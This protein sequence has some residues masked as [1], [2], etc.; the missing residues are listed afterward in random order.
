MVCWYTLKTYSGCVCVSE[1]AVLYI[2]P[3]RHCAKC[4]WV[5]AK[6][7]V[8]TRD[9][10]NST[11]IDL[12]RC[13]V[14]GPARLPQIFPNVVDVANVVHSQARDRREEQVWSWVLF[15]VPA[16]SSDVAGSFS[17]NVFPLIGCLFSFLILV[18]FG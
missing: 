8:D 11:F 10:G 17:R 2:N 4:A 9:P 5:D 13:R 12:P 16:R 3:G 1:A 7:R 15:A 6:A 14:V 18:F